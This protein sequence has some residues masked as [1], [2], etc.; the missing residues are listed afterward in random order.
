MSGGTAW[1][2]TK[3]AQPKDVQL[4][5][6]ISDPSKYKAFDRSEQVN[7]AAAGIGEDTGIQQAQALGR[8]AQLGA[9]RSAG[10]ARVLQDVATQGARNLAG[11]RAQAAEASWKDQLA[12]MAAENQY[13]LGMTQAEN[14]KYANE[15]AAY[16]A[17]QDR[18]AQAKFG[19][20][21]HLGNLF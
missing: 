2:P 14:Q 12:Q 19:L 15:L 5:D 7:Q 17:E 3:Y 1:G 4:R 13:N 20:F 6:Y 21:G 11:A 8:A 10:T 16:Q 9:G 18:R